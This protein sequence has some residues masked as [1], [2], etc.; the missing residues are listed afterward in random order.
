MYSGFQVHDTLESKFYWFDP[1]RPQTT[2][3]GV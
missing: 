2:H 1:T 3:C